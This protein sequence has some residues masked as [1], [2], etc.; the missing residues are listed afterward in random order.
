GLFAPDKQISNAMEETGT[1]GKSI[2]S[3]CEGVG[4][5][6]TYK[7]RREFWVSPTQTNTPHTGKLAT[8]TS[9][10]DVSAVYRFTGVFVYVTLLK[11]SVKKPPLRKT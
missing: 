3:S 1:E 11:S 6:K 4:L 2:G 8:D 9:T 10:L 5:R 7:A